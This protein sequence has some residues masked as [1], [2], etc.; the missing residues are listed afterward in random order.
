MDSVGNLNYFVGMGVNLTDRY[1]RIE[2]QM[3]VLDRLTFL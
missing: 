3:E 2:A 1:R